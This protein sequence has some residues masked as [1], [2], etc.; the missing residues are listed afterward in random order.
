MVKAKAYELGFH[1][2]G[3]AAVDGV[4]D[5]EVER[6]QAWIA[7]GFHADMEWMANPKRQ[8]ISLV[9]P[10]ARS[11]VCVALNYYTAHQ[12]PEGEEYAKISRYGWG[13]DYHR[14]MHKKLKALSTWL[15]SLAEGVQACYYT[16]PAVFG[17][18]R[19][20]G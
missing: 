15:K 10:E 20:P 14:V 5:L 17:A 7:E 16:D 18:G 4:D 11:L 1:K 19:D 3:I 2:V 12:R 6:L 13:R 9:M 8:N